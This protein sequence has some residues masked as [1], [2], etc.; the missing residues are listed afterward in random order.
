MPIHTLENGWLL[1]TQH[2]A[3]VFGLNKA[4]LLTHRYWGTRLPYPEDY[5]PAISPGGYG[6]FDNPAQLTPEE[7]PDYS[8][9]K[10]IEPCVKVTFADG[11]RD[12]VLKFESA[13][14]EDEVLHIHLHDA[15]YPLRVTLHYRLHPTYDLIERWATLTNEGS[16]PMTIERAF[17]AQWHMPATAEQ[18]RL[19]HL[20]GRWFDELY[21]HREKLTPGVKVLESRRITS[22]HHHNPWFAIDRGN[23]EEEHG[24]V[25]FGLLEWSGNWKIAAEMTD[26]FSTRVSIGLNDWDFAWRLNGGEAFNTPPA[27]AGYTTDGF[28]AASRTLH[29]YMRETVLP[30]KN[31]VHKVLYD[32]WE[33]TIFDV[34]YASQSRLAEIAAGLGCEMFMIDDGWYKGRF[35]Q[36]TGAGD[37]WPDEQKFPE[38][39]APLI[40]RVN[41]MGMDFGLWF[42]PEAVNP[43]SDLYRAHPDWVINFPTRERRLARS[44]LLLNLGREDVREYLIASLDKMLSTFNIAYVNWDMNRNVSEPGWPDA[45]GDARELWVRYVQGLYHVW[46]TLREM[47]PNVIWQSCSGGGGR[48]DMGML[49]V[50]DMIWTSDNSNAS[51]R[52]S[53]QEGYT[54]AY[55]PTTMQAWVSDMEGHLPLSFRFHSSMCGALGVGANI[56]QWNEAELEEARKWIAVYKEVRHI[57]QFGDL[58]R[59]RPAQNGNGFS[60][61]QYLSK[62]KGEGV[63]LA[64]L[65]YN[66]QW[67][68]SLT[69]RL[70]S[71]EPE[72]R[73]TVEGF[74]GVRSGAGWMNTDLQFGLY[75][76]LKNYGSTLRKIRRV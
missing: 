6:P 2:T 44:A 8:D 30:H 10:Y 25:W 37:W 41:E 70:R 57:I 67:E 24:E 33:A 68:P 15:V 61:V 23:A 43:D 19:S 54:Q 62:D 76:G 31:L 73:Y 66:S 18:Y 59:L 69:V 21:L 52:L 16:D 42:E 39:L 74:E 72:A 65:T 3:Y 38:G 14:V 71:L 53:I 28:G 48:I 5:P 56:T 49:R 32:S 34:D 35:T 75:G 20:T 29:D 51:N 4:G 50:S 46:N 63:L 22:S 47:H 9:M 12:T 11:V 64:F 1:E 60:A 17:S 7:Y 45:P 36:D 27:Y 26:F 13:A 40:K 58:Y 55:P